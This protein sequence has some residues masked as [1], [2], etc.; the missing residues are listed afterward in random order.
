VNQPRHILWLLGLMVLFTAM[1]WPGLLPWNFS[2]VYAICFC[3][4]V[5][6]K[7]LRAWLV[8]VALMCVSDLAMNYFVYRP[9]GYS[10]FSADMISRYVLY[11]LLIFMGWRL[12]KTQ[13]PAVLI[14]GGVMGALAYFVAS[15]TLVWLSDP[16]YAK[17]IGGWVQSFT[18]GKPGFPPA[19]M[20]MRNTIASG[21]IFTAVI[22]FAVQYARANEADGVAKG[23]AS[24]TLPQD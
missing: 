20:F 21:A 11:L 5:Y 22:V 1:R 4:G 14:S 10:V 18:V 19:I 23:E 13:S 17:T 6:L 3:A 16:V 15:N 2:P 24:S 9:M 8:P 7:G 12:S